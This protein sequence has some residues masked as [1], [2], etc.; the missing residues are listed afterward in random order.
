MALFTKKEIIEKTI[1]PI[2]FIII[3][4][5]CTLIITDMQ[6]QNTILLADKQRDANI[7]L[8]RTTQSIKILE[9]YKNELFNQNGIK[10][11]TALKLLSSVSP[12][13]VSAFKFEKT[14]DNEI[15]Q[16]SVILNV[17]NSIELF[18]TSSRRDASFRII[19]IAKNTEDAKLKNQIIQ[20]LFDSIQKENLYTSY[21][22]NLYIMRTLSKI[23]TTFEGFIKLDK[24]NKRM[25]ELKKTSNYKDETFKNWT[26]TAFQQYNAN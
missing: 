11:E 14:K 22:V 21:R 12:K 5:I 13:F 16:N 17:I 20:T 26:D 23:D 25:E 9:I 8:E 2:T 15:F 18:Y 24:N 10:K 3:S 7:I 1:L 6:H 19:Q 4:T